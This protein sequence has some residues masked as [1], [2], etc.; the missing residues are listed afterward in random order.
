MHAVRLEIN[1]A[2]LNLNKMLE[3]VLGEAI[4]FVWL[5]SSLELWVE[6]DPAMLDQMVMNLCLNAKEALPQGGTLT[7]ETS[8]EEFDAERVKLHPESRPGQFACLRISDTGIGMEADVLKHLFEPFFTTKEIGTGTGLGL[9]SSQGIVSQHKGWI[10]VESVPGQGTSFRVYLPL[11]AKI[12]AAPAVTT[13]PL[14]L[15]GQ[16]ETILLVEDEAALLFVTSKGLTMLGYQVLSAV[17]GEEALELWKQNQDAIDLVLTD[18]RMP[19]GMNGL[20]LAQKLWEI[21]PLLK[22]IIMSGYSAEILN[23]NDAVKPGYTFLAKPFPFKVLSE[24]LRGC[25]DEPA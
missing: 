3:R 1:T 4:T 6:A 9:A 22:V 20:Q 21:K 23:D 17:N 2:L 8:C 5:P 14:T 24:T 16:N 25:L 11:S 7:L 13:R 19:K 12:E 15:K 18:M 10:N